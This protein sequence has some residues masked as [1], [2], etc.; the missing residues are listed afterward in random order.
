VIGSTE[1]EAVPHAQGGG[2][3]SR[4]PL[5]F[6]VALMRRR[7]DV[8]QYRSGSERAYLVNN[9]DYIRHVLVENHRNYSKA[10]NINAVFK[11]A[12]ADGLLTSEGQTWRDQRRL[13]RPAFHR[14]RLRGIGAGVTD[15]TE[16]MLARWEHV[17]DTGRTLDVADEMGLLTL[18]ITTRALFGWDLGEDL[19]EVGDDIGRALSM[20]VAHDTPQWLRAEARVNELV[21]GL[22]RSRRAGDLAENDLLTMMLLARDEETGEGLEDREVRDQVV[23]L[24]LAGYETTANALA[25]T[26]Y[27]LAANPG[28]R[29]LMEREISGMLGGRSPATEDLAVLGYIRRVLQESMRLYPPAWILGRRA[30]AQ[31]RLGD[32]AIPAGSVVAL[33]PYTM[34]RHP[35]YWDDP[36]AFDPDRFLPEREAARKAFA[37]YPFGGGPRLCIGHNFAMIEAQLIVATVARRYRLEIAEGH[38]V[39]P[40]RLFVLRPRGGLPM[41]VH[42]R[43]TAA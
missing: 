9:P 37:Y 13:M 43:S 17:A 32:H 38:H 42:R 28:R 39:E 29:S 22:I 4:D 41:T 15:A 1:D 30:L 40:E 14:D 35:G 23:T 24:L 8:A 5:A 20:L 21:Y 36:E 25:W 6:L 3:A 27:L 31:D 2:R 33:S 19:Q 11:R 10:T 16:A 7:G 34:H 12:V 18:G 26:W